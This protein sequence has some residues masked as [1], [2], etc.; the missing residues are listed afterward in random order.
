MPIRLAINGFGR[1]GRQTA[2]ALFEKIRSEELPQDKIILVAIND[3][4]DP[5]TL[6]H[7][8]K[9]DSSY[10]I[11]EEEIGWEAES[12][13]KSFVGE[14]TVGNESIGVINEPDPKKLPWKELKIDIVIEST[15]RFVDKEGASAH[16]AAGA[17]KVIISAPAKDGKVGTYVI[18]VNDQDIGKNEDI[19]SNASCTTNCIAPIIKVMNEKFGIVKSMMTTVHAFTADQVLVDGPHKD[20]RRARSASINIVPTTTGAAIAATKTIPELEGK[21]DG[22]SIR[23]PVPVGSISDITMLLK[24]DTS[25]EEINKFLKGE[26]DMPHWDQI[27]TYTEDPLVSNDI[28]GNSHSSIID[29]SLTQ[30]I[31]GNLAKIVAWYDNEWGYSNRLID[32]VARLEKYL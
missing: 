20:L 26:C 32:Q 14:I 19:I 18:G 9:Y 8:F 4:T 1:I 7:L 23:V 24:D 15:G 11:L 13:N 31:D 22:L 5:Q 30:V 27:M 3:L 12:E 2:R 10:G 25:V 28:V 17:K 21:F 29:L 6:A 16:I